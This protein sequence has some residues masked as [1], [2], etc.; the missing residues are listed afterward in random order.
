[1]KNLFV[2][3]VVTLLAVSTFGQTKITTNEAIMVSVGPLVDGVDGITPEVSI[4][5]TTLTVEGYLENDATTVP[6]R[7]FNFVPTASGGAN[8]MALITSSVSGVY[9]LELTAAQLNITG[10]LRVTIVDTDSAGITAAPWWKDYILCAATVVDN[11]HSEDVVLNTVTVSSATGT[12]VTIASGGGAG[13]AVF[14]TGEGSAAGLLVVGGDGGHGAD[15]VGGGT[16][17][18]GMRIYS[19]GT[20]NP[21]LTVEGIA[22]GAAVLFQGGT[23]GHGIEVIAGGGATGPF[24][25]I[26]LTAGTNG[27]GFSGTIDITTLA[28]M[29]SAFWTASD[30]DANKAAGTMGRYAG[31]K[32]RR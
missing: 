23:S 11:V 6:L 26:D 4:D 29:A 22:A 13:N 8:D 24:N 17:G 21:G 7:V 3:F 16:Q 1:M 30:T 9:S 2:V 25:A 32:A 15:F 19:D 28:S 12:A 27:Y 20:N 5:V 10:R 31:R 18:S 14:L